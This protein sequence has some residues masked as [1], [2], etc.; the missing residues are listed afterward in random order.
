MHISTLIYEFI[1]SAIPPISV[2]ALLLLTPF[3]REW[4]L[5][6]VAGHAQAKFNEQLEAT[7]FDF[8]K[9]I[10][11]LKHEMGLQ[12]EQ[13]KSELRKSE[14]AFKSQLQVNERYAK[15]LTETT[16]AMRSSRDEALHARRLKA[17]EQL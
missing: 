12:A 1:G 10:E 7:K 15:L 11:N 8:G 9:Q 5:K 14:E 13:T 17:V 4:L 2:I 3:V 16:L 6:R